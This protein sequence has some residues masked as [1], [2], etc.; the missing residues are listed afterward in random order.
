MYFN[1]CEQADGENHQYVIITLSVT[2]LCLALSPF[3]THY[4]HFVVFAIVSGLSAGGIF[5]MTPS[6]LVDFIGIEN[7]RSSMGIMVL[8]QGLTLGLS[9][10]FIGKNKIVKE[11]ILK[12][13]KNFA[14]LLLPVV[15][16]YK[17]KTGGTC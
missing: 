5:A 3:Y 14:Y 12:N 8:G 1:L 6:V 7:F 17:E 11:H 16:H 2:T 4:W 15:K 13:L 10:P 9:A